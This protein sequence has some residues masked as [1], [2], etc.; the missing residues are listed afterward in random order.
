MPK[1]FLKSQDP[2][3]IPIENWLSWSASTLEECILD[4]ANKI[5]GIIGINK[6][7]DFAYLIM[8]TIVPNAIGDDSAILG[9]NFDASNEPSLVFIDTSDF[10]FSTVI[11][12][13]SDIPNEIRPEEPLPSK[14]FR[15][16]SC[17]SATAEL[18]LA[19]FPM[20]VP[21]L[22]G[23]EAI[24]ASIHIDDF[25]EKLKKMSPKHAIWANRNNEKCV[26]KIF[27]R[28]YKQ[29]NHDNQCQV[30]HGSLSW[31]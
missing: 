14:F 15:G 28:V 3:D 9:N 18:G 8:P 16:T 11:E 13:Y 6:A 31:W 17:E 19:R 2:P 10:G 24:E 29:N 30:C 23:M 7:G 25:E 1:S 12:K 20:V 22:F 5:A 27:D 21:V 4:A 26:N